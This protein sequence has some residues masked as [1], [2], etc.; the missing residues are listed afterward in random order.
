MYSLEAVPCVAHPIQGKGSRCAD[1]S[2]VSCSR[3]AHMRRHALCL[4]VVV[5]RLSGTDTSDPSEDDRRNAASTQPTLPNAAS[6][7]PRTRRWALVAVVIL[8]FAA[9][10]WV[11]HPLWVAILLGVVMAVSAQ[12]PYEAL[13]RRLG[14]RHDTL[15]AAIVTLASGI[16]FTIVGGLVLFTF[17]NELMK[18]VG[19]IDTSGRHGSLAGLIGERGARGLAE[20]GF[21]TQRINVWARSE[22]EAAASA[23]ATVAAVVV[24]TTSYGMLALVIALTTMY[25]MLFQ[26]KELTRRIERISPL[27]PRHTRALI[28]EARVVGRDAFLGTLATAFIQGALGGIGYA[29]LGVP[30]PV[31]WAV[32]TAL[33]SFLPVVGTLIVWV[34]LSAWLL[35]D[36]HP[37]RAILL[38]LYGILIV[39]S[40]ADYV[41]RPRIVGAR[42]DNHPL[43]TLIALLGGI[44]VFGLAGLIIAPIVMS[45]AVSAFRI[46]ERE[47][48]STAPGGG[49]APLTS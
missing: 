29:I 24:R 18:V 39:T 37:V 42:G 43:L 14:S 19:H 22:L 11:A 15:A 9:A 46:Y 10:A 25:Y 21:D 30:Q 40:L 28:S 5:P 26:G 8:S 31:T 23:L 16:L 6:Y 27:E 12:R 7:V 33:A 48:R 20:L 2:Q 32:A 13:L 38:V 36:G 1:P 41:I 35:M 4:L 17:T 45:V 47:M 34:P 44:E 3:E 49:G